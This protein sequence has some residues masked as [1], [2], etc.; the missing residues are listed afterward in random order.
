[1]VTSKSTWASV[2]NMVASEE[3][4]KNQN[5]AKRLSDYFSN[6]SSIREKIDN[7]TF[8]SGDKAQD[9]IQSRMWKLVDPYVAIA[10]EKMNSNWTNKYS[11]EQIKAAT[12]DLWW[13]IEKMKKYYNAQEWG[14]DKTWAI[15]DYIQH[16]W[17]AILVLD[18]L[19]WKSQ[20]PYK[21][22]E[23]EKEKSWFE[24]Y[25]ASF[26]STPAQQIWW[27]IKI[28][29]KITWAGDASKEYQN[30][31]HDII[32][33]NATSKDYENYKKE[34]YK[35]IE[36]NTEPYWFMDWIKAILKWDMSW[37]AYEDASR[38]R[39]LLYDSYDKA[40]NEWFEW[41]VEDYVDYTLNMWEKTAESLADSIINGAKSN[42]T[43]WKLSSDLWTLSAIW[44]EMATSLPMA[45]SE[46]W[47][48]WWISN[49]TIWY[50]KTVWDIA[51][52]W[53]E[54]QALE[55]AYNG[56]L[57]SLSD[58]E[59][60][61]L[62]NAIWNAFF[63][64]V[65]KVW[66]RWLTKLWWINKNAEEAIRT[67]WPE[68]YNRAI[69][70]IE[71]W[72]NNAADTVQKEIWKIIDETDKVMGKDWIEKWAAK[73]QVE[74]FWIKSDKTPQNLVDN[75]NE[76]LATL[77]DEGVSWAKTRKWDLPKLIVWET[78]EEAAKRR[79]QEAA[80]KR[81]EEK[82][83]KKAS[84]DKPKA[85][86]KD[87]TKYSEQE[88]K[89]METVKRAEEEKLAKEQA[90]QERER[91]Y[92]LRVENESSMKKSSDDDAI[93]VIDMFKTEWNKMFVDQWAE[94]NATNLNDLIKNIRTNLKWTTYWNNNAVQKLINWL[95]RT[96][97]DLDLWTEYKTA[98]EEHMKAKDLITKLR[99]IFGKSPNNQSNASKQIEL[100]WVWWKALQKA[101]AAEVSELF[102]QIKNNYWIDLNNKIWMWIAALSLYDREAAEK[103]LRE[104]YPSIPWLTEFMIKNTMNL[105][106]KLWW[107]VISN[108][109]NI[110]NV[111]NTIWNSVNRGAWIWA[112]W[113][114][115]QTDF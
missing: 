55:D 71:N 15:D 42:Y 54:F 23:P 110:N 29:D 45:L 7:G 90:R 44:V 34:W 83:I 14:K 58:Y 113:L 24:N 6:R 59:N 73:E 103:M 96:S 77:W 70:M 86:K 106:G 93:D 57:S 38:S 109:W 67:A 88:L 4:N 87:T 16:W 37:K 84:K 85:K 111:R 69:N 40:L 48:V 36:N 79:L 102:T 52:W 115:T 64:A 61:I 5:K 25:A 114:W 98:S 66:K 105:I 56:N 31:V 65:W 112:M 101:D 13:T 80:K 89:D 81:A 82:A 9:K 107:K 10:S 12:Q 63:K 76:E 50:L 20:S 35:P 39:K 91:E 2:Y 60:S 30:K 33:K 100:A 51:A 28:L 47:L 68:E 22:V 18:Y 92:W 62:W 21:T 75:I 19:Q 32:R 26:A 27:T 72:W 99:D 17:N 1:M 78:E 74:K 41:S 3:N 97:E 53:L 46:L 95:K 108:E 49:W 8:T 43:E 94:F 104:I 11:E